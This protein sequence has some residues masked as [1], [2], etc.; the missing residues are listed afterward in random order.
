MQ[1][2]ER[3]LESPQ[4]RRLLRGFFHLEATYGLIRTWPGWQI[5]Q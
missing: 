3:N 5:G 2:F 4:L 1:Q